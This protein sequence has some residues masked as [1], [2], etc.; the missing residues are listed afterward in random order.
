MRL[1][2]ADRLDSLLQI[3]EKSDDDRT[4]L[5]IQELLRPFEYTKVDRIIDVIFTAAQDVEPVKEIDSPIEATEDPA[6]PGAGPTRRYRQV[7]TDRDLL[8]KTRAS[9]VNGLGHKLGVILQRHR[10]TLFWTP[11]KTVRVCAAVSKRYESTYKPYWYAYHPHWDTFLADGSDSFFVLA[12]MDKDRAFA[13]PHAL[14]RH[15]LSDCSVT[16]RES[17][18][19]YWYIA[20]SHDG[21]GQV[22]WDLTKVQKKVDLSPFEFPLMSTVNAPSL[23]LFGS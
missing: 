1:I 22:I 4:V 11:D 3:K 8:N 14:V 23:E 10:Q 13:I 12:C 16:E 6:E 15:H 19:S 9:A 20:L 5:Q 17:G 2:G 18:K 21:A 7:R